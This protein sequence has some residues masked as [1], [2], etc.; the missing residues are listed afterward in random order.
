VRSDRYEILIQS[1]FRATDYGVLMTDLDGKDILCNPRFGAIFDVDPDQVAQL[2]QEEMR[3][4]ALNRMK[5]PDAY[6]KLMDRLY[7]D[8]RLEFED[9]VELVAPCPMVVRR[10]SG[11]VLDGDNCV[12]GRFWTF[13]DITETCRLREEVASYTHRLEE[14]LEQQAM[15]LKAAQESILETAQM[16][17]VGTLA[18]GIAHDLRNILT[19][20]RLEMAAVEA[21]PCQILAEK[22]LDRLYTLTHSLLALAEE[23]TL[24]FSPV[25]VSEIIDFVFRLVEA[26]AEVD[27]ARLRKRVVRDLPPVRGNARR[28]EHLFVNL[29]QN[30]LNAISATGGTVT[31]TLRQEGEWVRVDVRDTGPGIAP[32]HLQHIFQ[33]FFT[34]RANRTGL[35]LFSARRIVE[36]HNGEIKIVSKAGKG[37]CVSL[38][39][40]AAVASPL[41]TTEATAN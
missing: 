27:G 7:A 15:A 32:K 19:T 21:S 35:G 3:R 4:L 23:E 31:V 34:T 11:P 37:A 29:L 20:L 41:M 9:E 30:A 8:P 39:L 14:R 28:L 25:D 40:P 26:Q 1:L 17:A 16:R 10:H 12:I 18:V 13:L 24:H 5:D 38:W 6:V 36:A 33:P 22:Q 2:P